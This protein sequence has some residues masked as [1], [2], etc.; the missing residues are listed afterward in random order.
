[1]TRAKSSKQAHVFRVGLAAALLAATPA[2]SQVTIA[3]NG[4]QIA[5]PVVG[6]SLYDGEE[7]F[8]ARLWLHES[9][10]LYSVTIMDKQ[11]PENS[12]TGM[13]WGARVWDPIISHA[14]HISAYS[15]GDG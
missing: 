9:I 7:F 5:A 11:D 8:R 13:D 12:Y 3:E 6:F 15:Q 2:H 4:I 10:P 1:M 14:A